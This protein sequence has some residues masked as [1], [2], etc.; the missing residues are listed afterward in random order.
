MIC[1]VCPEWDLSLP[2]AMAWS[3]TSLQ[4]GMQT[5]RLKGSWGPRWAQPSVDIWHSRSSQSRVMTIHPAFPLDFVLQALF[6]PSMLSTPSPF[7]GLIS[8]HSKGAVSFYKSAKKGHAAQSSP[9]EGGQIVR[10]VK[11]TCTKHV[12]GVASL[13]PEQFTVADV[14]ICWFYFTFRECRFYQP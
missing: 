9:A 8:V 11:R 5:M 4:S 14:L 3:R 2:P 1:E 6:L 10:T 7:W 13:Q 12:I